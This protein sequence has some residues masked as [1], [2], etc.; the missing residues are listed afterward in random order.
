MSLAGNG[1]STLAQHLVKLDARWN[2]SGLSSR[3]LRPRRS[4]TVVSMCCERGTGS[5]S[6]LIH[7]TAGLSAMSLMYHF[8]SSG[9]TGTPSEDVAAGQRLM[10]FF[11]KLRFIPDTSG[12]DSK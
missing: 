8:T 7:M 9:S 5:T 10:L 2:M 11:L 6:R 1:Q 12:G 4:T 3:G